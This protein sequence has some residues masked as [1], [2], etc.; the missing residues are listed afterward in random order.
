MGE[1]YERR[2]CVFWRAYLMSLRGIINSTVTDHPFG[3]KLVNCFFLIRTKSF[4]LGFFP[5]CFV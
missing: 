1:A 5:L 3:G 2:S 4:R